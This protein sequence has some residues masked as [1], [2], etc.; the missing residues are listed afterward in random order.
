MENQVAVVSD[1]AVEA[2]PLNGV[3]RYLRPWRGRWHFSDKRCPYRPG[4]ADPAFHLHL[5]EEGREGQRER[6]RE[7]ERCIGSYDTEWHSLLPF[8]MYINDTIKHRVE[9]DMELRGS[10]NET[11]AG[12]PWDTRSPAQSLRLPEKRSQDSSRFCLSPACGAMHRW[13]NDSR[14]PSM[15]C[16]ETQRHAAG[17]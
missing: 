4:A 1:K 11:A 12:T 7:R 3:P 5:R 16:G 9:G 6:E 14:Y 8:V 13:H 17:A 10:S 2:G 15:P